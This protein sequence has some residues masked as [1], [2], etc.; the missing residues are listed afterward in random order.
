MKNLRLMVSVYAVLFF[1]I[2]TTANAA[3]IVPP[4]L[5][6]GEAYQLAFVTSGTTVATSGDINDYNAFVQNAADAANIG[7]SLGITWS[8]IAST[9]STDANTNC[10][11][12]GKVFNMNGELLASSFSDFWDGTH[13]L[14]VGID[15]NENGTARNFNVW[16][17]SNADGS[18][19]V[20]YALG[21]PTARWGESTFSS[22]GWITHGTVSTANTYSLYALS[23]PLTAPIPV[24]ASVW[25]FGSGLMGLIGISR[26]KKSI[27]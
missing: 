10:V 18:T 25:L 8:A 6:P 13:T 11:V 4:G 5:A 24:P 3:L 12:S 27:Y 1:L 19:A 16:T 22:S 17:G 2:T 21:D 20:G 14:N 15:F 9:E 23:Q 7:S 26:S